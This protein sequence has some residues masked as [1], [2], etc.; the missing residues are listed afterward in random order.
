MSQQH[1]KIQRKSSVAGVQSAA[2]E[3]TASTTRDAAGDEFAAVFGGPEETRVIAP[4]LG[5]ASE[6]DEAEVMLHHILK[7]R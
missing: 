5:R 1:Q 6:V 3:A 2:R 4:Y 7:A